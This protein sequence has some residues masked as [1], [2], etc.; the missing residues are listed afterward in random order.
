MA[1]GRLAD[2]KV[3]LQESMGRNPQNASVRQR[4]YQLAFL[5][6]DEKL[7]QEQIDWA[8]QDPGALARMGHSDTEAYFG[9]LRKARELSKNAEDSAAHNDF[10]ERAVL[11]RAGEALREAEFGN[12]TV[13]IEHAQSALANSPGIDTQ[14]V[15][16]LALA[17]SGDTLRAREVA[18]R[19]SNTLQHASLVQN[20]WLPVIRAQIEIASN[21]PANAASEFKKVLEHRGIVG[22][23]PI[24]AMARLGL[25]RAFA[26]SGNIPEA[27]A[28]YQE[29]FT[30]WKDADG[31]TPVLSEARSEFTRVN[32]A[33]NQR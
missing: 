27:R 30:L 19:L 10:K 28:A 33:Q 14:V 8:A 4:M 11:F 32:A 22:N 29:F 23:S 13:A 16:A 5:Q 31:E 25:A 1:M 12:S 17:Q 2:A 24:G 9:H 3:V 26:M 18:A 21:N 7:L 20:Y 15:A 6:G